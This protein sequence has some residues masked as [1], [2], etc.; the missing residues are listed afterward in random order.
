MDDVSLPQWIKKV[1]SFGP[2]YLVR[3]KFKDFGFLADVDNLSEMKSPKVPL[4]KIM[5]D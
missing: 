5:Q 3:D 1:L 4:E 2:K